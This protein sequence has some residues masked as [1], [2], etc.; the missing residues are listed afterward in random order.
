MRQKNKISMAIIA[1]LFSLTGVAAQSNTDETIITIKRD[2]FG[3]PHIYAETTYGL[4]YGYGYSIAQDRLF[5]LE[6]AK[7]SAQGNVAAVL[8]TEFLDLDISVREHYNPNAIKASLAALP[9]K[10]R[11]ILEGYANGINQWIANI[12]K[13]PQTLT[14]KQFIDNDFSPTLWSDFDVAM[15]FIG[16]MINRFGDYNTELQNQQLLN[17]LVKKH[18]QSKGKE[19]FTALLPHYSDKSINTI[20]ENEW[21]AKGRNKFKDQ[22]IAKALIT[23][24]PPSKLQLIDNEKVNLASL[25]RSG[26]LN[27]HGFSEAP[28]S[29]V[30]LLGKEKLDNAKSV[31]INGPQFGF[32][33]PAYTYSIGLHGAG[34]DAV[35]NSP[36]GYPLVQFGHNGYISWGSTWGA[37]DNV[38][39]F[40]LILNPNNPEEYLYKGEYIPFESDQQQIEV[41][42]KE[43]HLI[44]IRRSVYGPVVKYEPKNNLAYSK[45]RGWEGKELSTLMAWSEISKAKNHQQWLNFVADSA[46]NVN[47][48]YTD[49][50]GNIAYALGGHY[51]VRQVGF[52]GITPTPG[53]GSADWLGIYPFNTNPQVIN[54]KSGY[55]ANWNNRPAAGFPN[56]DQWWYSWDT[57]DRMT[58]IKNKVDAVKHLTTQQAWEIM[59]NVS[60]I[61]ANAPGFVPALISAANKSTDPVHHKAAKILS[62][63]DYSNTDN[64]ANGKYDNPA[65]ALFRL[66]LENA[67]HS[68]YSPIIPSENLA[69]FTDTGYGKNKVVKNGYNIQV[70]TKAFANKD[71]RQLLL[72]GGDINTLKLTALSK[73]MNTLT[74]EYGPDTSKWLIDVDV[75]IFSNKNYIGV[76]QSSDSEVRYTPIALNRGTENNMTIFKGDTTQA[77]EVAAPGQ[78]GFIAPDG[79]KSPHYEDQYDIFVNQIYKQ[80][81]LNFDEVNSMKKSEITLNVIR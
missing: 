41:K 68:V 72:Q 12:Q 29:N 67:L 31:L 8:G 35:G 42:D 21:S 37:G 58:L 61:D 3:T 39:L 73:A 27:W 30:L 28:Y 64:N 33:Q 11:D 5:Q 48:Y 45:K 15:V 66:W 80:V 76:P 59:M 47:W 78:S 51:P 53:D 18:G 43:K 22:L 7:R 77:F 46:I 55:I 69:W 40:Q 17:A 4:F 14:P 50:Q 44:T 65:T 10:D 57:V 1:S 36:A 23:A 19:L 62:Q 60:L 16:S 54:P 34:F 38:D 2:N 75:L 9:P 52:N 79:K 13:S 26:T 32:Y 70:G 20:A 71:K 24:T 6:M 81:G 25:S 56:P 74:E 49:Q 63:W